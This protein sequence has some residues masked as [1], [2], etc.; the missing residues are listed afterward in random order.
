M[1]I[2]ENY[3]QRLSR[4]PHNLQTA[5]AAACAERVLRIF[6]AYEETGSESPIPPAGVALAWQFAVEG[7]VTEPQ[8]HLAGQSI[9]KVL[10]DLDVDDAYTA[11]KD[12]GRSALYAVESI[13]DKSGFSAAKA[14]TRATQAVEGYE[15]YSEAGVVG[16]GEASEQQWQERALAL[17]ETWNGKP[18]NRAMF[19]ILGDEPPV[20][21]S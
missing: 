5:F 2:I 4:L 14:A 1:I 15:G 16:A 7:N 19:Q 10:P 8:A 13:L 9:G 21:F 20:W 11:Q 18:V 12:A 17:V 3:T 6:W